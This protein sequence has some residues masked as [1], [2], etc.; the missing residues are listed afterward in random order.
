[1]CTFIRTHPQLSIFIGVFLIFLIIALLSGCADDATSQPGQIN[2]SYVWTAPTT[3]S[4]VAAYVVEIETTR[5]DVTTVAT[6]GSLT[7]SIT[8]AA[9]EDATTRIRV[10]GYDA[11]L[12]E[13]GPPGVPGRPEK[14][15]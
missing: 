1:M 4:P 5:G 8:I 2:L 13:L 12:V 7:A 10:A 14:V 3:G 6:T 11:P 15:N 9:A